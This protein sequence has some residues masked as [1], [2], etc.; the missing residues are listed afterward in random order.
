MIPCAAAVGA[1]I[2][3]REDQ[4]CRW[5]AARQ[6]LQRGGPWF[7]QHFTDLHEDYWFSFR[8]QVGLLSPGQGIG[9]GGPASVKKIL[10][11]NAGP[12]KPVH[13]LP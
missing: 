2:T 7:L 10:A 3:R 13:S 11:W 8:P 1:A 6:K 4:Q 12:L 9:S 5:E